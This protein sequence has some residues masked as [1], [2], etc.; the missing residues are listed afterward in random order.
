MNQQER[1]LLKRRWRNSSAFLLLNLSLVLCLL[2]SL[3]G[4]K[5]EK[6]NF[7]VSAPLTQ[8]AVAKSV[9]LSR[10]V[11]GPTN[12]GPAASNPYE[13]N[14]YDLSQG[15]QLFSAYNCV[16]CHAHGG[17]GMGPPLMDATWI[18][19]SKPAQIHDSIVEGRPN[20]MPSFRGLIPDYQIWQLVAYVRSLSGQ[21]SPT[22]ASGRDD[23][24]KGPSPPNSAPYATPKNVA[25]PKP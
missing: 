12:P 13:A 3:G 4:C 18:Y 9:R 11:P 8:T 2:Y 22:A 21:V 7:Q 6:R 15:Q 1:K 19:G 17:G 5:R 10:L 24:M 20:G 14:A 25:V 16:G 23:H